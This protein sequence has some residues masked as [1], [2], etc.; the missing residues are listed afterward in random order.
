MGKRFILGS[1]ELSRTTLYGEGL[2]ETFRWK[3]RPPVHLSGHLE[4]MRRGAEFLGIPFP[5]EA[6]LTR[7]VHEAVEG[8]GMEDAY[9]KLCLLSRGDLHFTSCPERGEVTVVVERY[10]E[11][12]PE[13]RCSLADFRRHSS[14][15]VLRFKTTNYLEN[16][17]ARRQ[18]LRLGY[19]EAIFLNERGEVTEGAASN[20]FWVKGD[21]LLTPSI[22]CGIL[23]GITRGLLIS[24]SPRCGFEAVEGRFS[25]EDLLAADAAFLTN[26]L[27]GISQLVEVSGKTV[28]RN[29]RIFHALREGLFRELGWAPDPSA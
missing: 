19:D 3:G 15:P 28:N 29:L 17:L 12:R 27:I 8:S 4:R 20:L 6:E 5:G 14:S 11:P 25:L 16:V 18:A 7:T 21:K 24:I 26:S 10:R 1:G 9:V 2:F 23:P 22:D 13:M